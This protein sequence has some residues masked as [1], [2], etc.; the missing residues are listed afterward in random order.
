MN[1]RPHTIAVLAMTADGKIA[2]YQKSP[3]HFGSANDKL[4]LQQQV[5]VADG[6]IFG[7]N[8]LRAY[9][10]TMS[11][12]NPELLRSRQKRS[13]PPQPVQIVVSASANL[14]SQWRFFQQPV[15]R[16]LITT[17]KNVKL[18]QGKPEFERILTTKSGEEDNSAIDWTS[19]FVQLKDQGLHQLAILGG[20]ELIASLLAVGLIDEL[21]LTICP[22][23]FGGRDAPT[24]VSGRGFTQLEGKKL[25]LTQVKQLEQ[26]IFLHYQVQNQVQKSNLPTK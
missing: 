22:I 17:P 2:D 8:T 20:G 7:A 25:K 24:P 15:P 9:G 10:T 12:F 4:H 26:E 16:W 5:A 13:Q 19:I 14:D 6:V 18:W 3:A 11:V 23:I 21:W 1:E